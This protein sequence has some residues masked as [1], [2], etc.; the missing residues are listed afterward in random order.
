M[1]T[2]STHCIRYHANRVQAIAF[3]AAL[4]FAIAFMACAVMGLETGA[5]VAAIA[6]AFVL[7]ISVGAWVTGQCFKE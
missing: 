1:R 3:F 5:L 4:P 6:G 7:G 2:Y